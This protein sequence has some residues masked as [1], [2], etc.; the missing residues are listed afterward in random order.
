[1]P[2]PVE[3][4]VRA[5]ATASYL[6]SVGLLEVLQSVSDDPLLLSF[7]ADSVEPFVLALLVP[8]VTFVAG[9]RAKHTPRGH[10]AS[11]GG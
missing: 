3:A 9:W 6:A 7:L 11:S 10:T 1:M 4:K 2:H 8:A 5:G